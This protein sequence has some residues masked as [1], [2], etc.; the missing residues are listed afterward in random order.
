MDATPAPV[1]PPAVPVDGASSVVLVEGTSDAT[2]LRTLAELQGRDLA[3]ERVA[4]VPM[5]GATSVA[6]YLQRFGPPGL[7]LHVVGLCDTREEPFVRRG[8]A[9]AGIAEV[10]S[11]EETERAGFSVCVVDLE[12]ELIRALGPAGVLAVLEEHGD[13]SRFRRFQRQPA[14]R[15]EP[16]AHQLRRFLGTT[17]GR[18]ALYAQR[19]VKAAGPDRA[20]APLRAVL[21]RV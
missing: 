5:G 6:K 7:G 3:G 18:K 12:D 9:A 15:R 1:P 4:V 2:A 14:H 8:L 17:S 19:L 10:T 16:V 11:R 20:P 21:A 13:L